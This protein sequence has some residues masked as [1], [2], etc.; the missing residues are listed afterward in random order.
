MGRVLA[1]PSGGWMMRVCG[2]IKPSKGI[3]GAATEMMRGR[4]QLWILNGHFAY[5]LV[6]VHLGRTDGLLI[7]DKNVHR[8]KY[9]MKW[10]T[11]PESNRRFRCFPTKVTARMVDTAGIEPAFTDCQP[12]VLPLNYAPE[13]ERGWWSQPTNEATLSKAA[14]PHKEFGFTTTGPSIT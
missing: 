2:L 9:T 4:Q 5:M 7:Q 11:V 8:I 3:A 13:L 14:P 1:D 6:T 12:V 10:W